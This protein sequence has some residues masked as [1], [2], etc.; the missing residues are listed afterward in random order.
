MTNSNVLDGYKTGGYSSPFT[1]PGLADGG[2]QHLDERSLNRLD[3]LL[4]GLRWCMTAVGEWEAAGAHAQ[5]TR[6]LFAVLFTVWTDDPINSLFTY[7]GV[8]LMRNRPVIRKG[9][10]EFRQMPHAFS[11]VFP[12]PIEEVPIAI[13]MGTL[14]LVPTEADVTAV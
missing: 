12:N 7:G 8:D 13:L 4:E 5:Q 11:V 14:R 3:E 10:T 9:I 2:Q 6:R 1:A